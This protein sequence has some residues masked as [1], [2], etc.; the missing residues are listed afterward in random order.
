LS[1]SPRAAV[2]VDAGTGARAYRDARERP[3]DLKTFKKVATEHVNGEKIYMGDIH[4]AARSF[5][6]SHV[7]VPGNK[8]YLQSLDEYREKK[9]KE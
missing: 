1:S 6:R 4:G 5:A 9:A 3:E 7:V 8:S 2:P